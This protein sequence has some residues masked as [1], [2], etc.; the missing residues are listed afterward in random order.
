[1]R[2]AKQQKSLQEL[3]DEL[4][5]IESNEQQTDDIFLNTQPFY[6][7]FFHLLDHSELNVKT[8]QSVSFKTALVCLL[9]LACGIA[10]QRNKH[11]FQNVPISDSAVLNNTIVI[12]LHIFRLSPALLKKS[13]TAYGAPKNACDALL[14][15]LD[16]H[17]QKHNKHAAALIT[18]Y[19][20]QRVL[21]VIF[22]RS[23]SR[24]RAKYYRT[25]LE[26]FIAY[27]I[28]YLGLPS[29]TLKSLLL[30]NAYA[31]HGLANDLATDPKMTA[32]FKRALIN[33]LAMAK[34]V[35]WMIQQAQH[36]HATS[37]LS[38][39]FTDGPGFNTVPFMIQHTER[40]HS[41]R[42]DLGYHGDYALLNP[43][44]GHLECGYATTAHHLA[45]LGP[46][47]S[48]LACGIHNTRQLG[49]AKFSRIQS[50]SI[51]IRHI[52]ILQIAEFS[53]ALSTLSL[54]IDELD[55]ACVHQFSA[56]CHVAVLLANNTPSQYQS[57]REWIT[58]Q[59]IAKSVKAAE[60]PI[61]L[62]PYD[63]QII[64]AANV[65]Y[66]FSK[67]LHQISHQFENVHT[68]A[69]NLANFLAENLPFISQATEDLRVA[70]ALSGNASLL[71]RV[72]A[73][74]DETVLALF[75]IRLIFIKTQWL[76]RQPSIQYRNSTKGI[77]RQTRLINATSRSTVM[78]VR[79]FKS[80]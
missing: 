38:I 4:S 52:S 9:D 30:L 11:N 63:E 47:L 57:I 25:D 51:I 34:S 71:K 78:A 8:L 12:L 74:A 22:K 79:Y 33:P 24:I 18:A 73:C 54:S 59:S 68:L 39:Q 40:Y 32:H 7:G 55:V 72:T 31:E 49:H 19:S 62:L 70:A 17:I 66:Q 65:L 20:S 28:G 69:K 36:A 45:T 37:R 26:L 15:A 16:Q 64:A 44:T 56:M 1:M 80:K 43:K 3:L 23:E 41:L 48:A 14:K 5:I 42:Q 6:D 35:R 2:M 53:E 67:L 76:D 29:L 10:H 50:V 75:E 13:L 61:T 60:A 27:S 77:L 58:F 21:P 46:I